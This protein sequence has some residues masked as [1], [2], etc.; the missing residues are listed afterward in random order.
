MLYGRLR[1]TAQHEERQSHIEASGKAARSV[2][3]SDHKLKRLQ[4][5]TN[6]LSK[7]RISLQQHTILQ[8]AQMMQMR[9]REF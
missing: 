3:L 4:Q 1:T 5:I 7:S 8:K 6:G 2:S 9:I